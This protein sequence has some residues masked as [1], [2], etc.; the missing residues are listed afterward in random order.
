LAAVF[1]GLL[2]P[3]VPVPAAA[4]TTPS[5]LVRL[6]NW[7]ATSALSALSENTSWDQDD[8]NHSYYMVKTGLVTHYEDPANPYYTVSGDTGAR[9]GNIQVSSTTT[10]TD[11]GAI[12]WWMAAP[13]HAMGMMD[14]RLTSTGYGSYREVKT[15]WQTGTTLDV[16]RGNSW[17]GGNFPVYFPG[18]GSVVPLTTFQG[19]ESPDPLQAC[20][21][22]VAPT[23][24][25]AFI[26]V[27]GNVNTQVTAHSFTGNGVALAHCVID[28]TNPTFTNNLKSRGG[29]IVI[30]QQPLA[31]GIQYVVNLTV[32]GVPYT[33]SFG[34]TNTGSFTPSAPAITGVVAG[35]ASAT[36]TWNPP[37][38]TGGTPITSYVVTAYIGSTAQS[39]QTLPPTATSAAFTGLTNGATYQ[40]TVAATNA[41]GT[42]PA[43]T[44]YSVTPSSAAVPPA[45]M[46]AVGT[47][48]YKLPSSDGVTWQ[49]MDATNLSLSFTPSVNSV[50]IISANVDLWTTNLGYNQDVGIWLNSS[51]NA[52]GIVAWKESGGSAG[53]FSPNAAAVQTTVSLSANV[54][55]SV[56]LEWKASRPAY[57]ATIFAGAGP[58]ADG[59]YSPTRLSVVLIPTTNLSTAV[60]TGQYPF[61]SSDGVTWQDMDAT[62]LT[63]TLTPTSSGTALVTANS[64]LWTS[65]SGY[66]QD[67]GIFV[68]VN[69]GADQLVGWKESGGSAGTFS[70]NAAYL[71]TTWPVTAGN[72][73]LFKIKWK[74]NRNA[75][76]A[77]IYAGAGPIGLNSYSPTRLTAI[78]EPT[79]SLT[80]TSSNGQYHLPGSDGATWQT[81]DPT[82]LKMQFTPGTTANYVVS[83]NIDLWT[84]NSGYNQD[85]G[86]FISG[87][88]FTTPTLLVWK[89]SGGSAGTFSPNAAYAE[90]VASLQ[91]GVTYTIWLS[92]KANGPAAGATIVAA[93]GPLPGGLYSPTR[94]TVIPQ[95]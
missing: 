76:G 40:F 54:T 36:F 2:V 55:Y 8:Y 81:I 94:L 62:K 28:S 72:A 6:N 3:S 80:T 26:E 10:A 59:K 5:W 35:D 79:G 1:G 75:A 51:Q 56:K 65:T 93:A 73:Y 71:L 15:G 7:R 37:S 32:N 20:P 88:S 24:L 67:I 30:P 78:F 92:W 25:P 66:N 77:T 39:S 18:N 52:P 49:D 9:N 11:D 17:T 68:S 42:G 90:T 60:S 74:A 34:V 70:P 69:G 61:P 38:S 83:A 48:Q 95:Q 45:R 63:T 4:A 12:D 47:L 44:S 85:I 21:G 22:Y 58:L 50:A 87:G 43:S 64:D 19:G 33:W 13:F 14:P 57:G 89:E 31:Q 16:L 84:L 91:S 41:A 46:T 86:I 82:A 53:T 23:G 29:V 27:G